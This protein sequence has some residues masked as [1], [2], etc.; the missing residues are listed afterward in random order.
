MNLLNMISL[1]CFTCMKGGEDVTNA[2]SMA[3]LFMLVIL[4]CVF[5][6]IF[7]F[8]R[9]LSRLEKNGGRK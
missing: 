7:K 3:I 1:G 6:G 8:I 9:H 2:A 5:F 4:L